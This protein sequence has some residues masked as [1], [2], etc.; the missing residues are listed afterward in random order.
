[1]K[2]ANVRYL[3]QA[4][5]I[6]AFYATLSL[7]FMPISFAAVQFRVSEALTV[8]PFFLP[9]AV[10]G[11][12]IGCVIANLFSPYGLL[13]I[14]AGSAATLIAALATRFIAVKMGDTKLSRL[15]APL[16]PVISNGVIVGLVITYMM[17]GGFNAAVFAVNGAQVAL[18]ELGVCYLLGLPLLY[19]VGRILSGKKEKDGDRI[20]K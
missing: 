13:D 16:P 15:L 2:N 11:L 1:V 14:A 7:A 10:P 6:A 18:G 5:I 19:A 4:G 9:S 3:V 8:L 20:Q 17:T 12:F